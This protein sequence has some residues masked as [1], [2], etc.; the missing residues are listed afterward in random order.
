MW[1]YCEFILLY[2]NISIKWLNKLKSAIEN[3]TK[4]TLKNWSNFLG[5]SKIE[6][7]FLR[8]LLL[9]NTQVLKVCKSFAKL[10]KSKLHKIYQSGR[11]LGRFLGPLQKTGFS[12]LGN[13]H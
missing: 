11:F 4:V 5:D 3:G 10:S 1:K 12:S 13:V 6:N 8:K 7:N 2:Q 9:T